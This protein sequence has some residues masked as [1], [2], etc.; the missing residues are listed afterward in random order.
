MSWPPTSA[1]P[2]LKMGM[3]AEGVSEEGVEREPEDV[4]VE[5]DD[6]RI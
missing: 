1:V 4:K 2:H 6:S 5:V 3:S